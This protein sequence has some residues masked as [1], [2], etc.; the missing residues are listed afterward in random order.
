MTPRAKPRREEL[1]GLLPVARDDD[2]TATRREQVRHRR[3]LV[4]VVVDH[5][6]CGPRGP[7]AGLLGASPLD[8]LVAIRRC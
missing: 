5:E 1:H 4:R 2:R 6:D 7:T 3:A 8:A